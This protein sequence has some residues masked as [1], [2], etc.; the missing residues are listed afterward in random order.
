MSVSATGSSSGSSSSGASQSKS[1]SESKS[2]SKGA[3][4]SKAESKAESKGASESS[5]KTAAKETSPTGTV[6]DKVEVNSPNEVPNPY[7]FAPHAEQVTAEQWTKDRTPGDGQVSKDDHL[8]GMLE[9]RGFTSA[10]IYAKDESGKTMFERVADANNLDNPNLIQAGQS[11]IIPSRNEPAETSADAS[12]HAQGLENAYASA[13]ADQ[14]LGDLKDQKAQVSSQADATAKHGDATA[15]A[16]TKQTLGNLDNA[17]VKAEADAKAASVTGD[18]KADATSDQK[19]GNVTDSRMSNAADAKAASVTGDA[20]ATSTANQKVADVLD[21]TLTNSAD[22]FAQ[23]VTGDALAEATANQ[24]AGN[25]KDSTLSNTAAAEAS[26]VT[27]DAAANTVA[28]TTVDSA[29]NS[30]IQTVADSSATTSS[31]EATT[32]A[33][34]T[35]SVAAIETST[36]QN[37]AQT[38]QTTATTGIQAEKAGAVTATDV[39]QGTATDQATTLENAT[40]PASVDQLA[41]GAQ[42]SVQNAEVEGPQVSVHQ[43]SDAATVNQDATNYTETPAGAA[44]LNSVNSEFASQ[45]STGFEQSDLKAEGVGMAAMA[46]DAPQA[47]YSV[48]GDRM[49]AYHGGKNGAVDVSANAKE[50]FFNDGAPHESA[51]FDPTGNTITGNIT[52]PDIHIDASR[53]ASVNGS[54]GNTEGNTRV[55]LDL[56]TGDPGT[57]P[58]G[59]NIQVPLANGEDFLITSGGNPQLQV[60]KPSGDLTLTQNDMRGNGVNLNYDVG[61]TNLHGN[62]DLSRTEGANVSINTA[63]ADHDVT[64]KGGPGS[65][66]T[67]QLPEGA[68][69]PNVITQEAS[70]LPTWLL[71]SPAQ[72]Y[73]QDNTQG[74]I[75]ALGFDNVV[76]MQGDKMVYNSDPAWQPPVQ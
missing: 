65:T 7:D 17:I 38:D 5:P 69:L 57:P 50:V 22:S 33:E 15:E 13:T 36:I 6:T 63:G 47:S 46:S 54:F 27:G 67:L 8:I 51:N 14:K 70:L 9:N 74:N 58:A 12:A 4:E 28:N 76:M 19:A 1:P 31:G 42:T 71:G 60:Q 64:F 72:G 49:T 30:N 75:R 16:K 59:D 66:M 73:I 26:S 35:T 32:T 45:T 2:A 37:T 56:P 68:T 24:A 52:S 41:Q 55:E 11:Y 10:E 25:V 21:S 48:D 40:A 39:V 3:S 20:T 43:T 18:A 53:S 34:A 29:A 23:T 62:V 44:N 61:Q